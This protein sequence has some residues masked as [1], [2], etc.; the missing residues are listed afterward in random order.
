MVT[1]FLSGGRGLEELDRGVDNPLPS[2]AE[3]KERVELYF[4]FPDGH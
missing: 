4:Y 1:L 3:I 2:R